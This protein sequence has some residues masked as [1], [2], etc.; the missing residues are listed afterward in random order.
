VLWTLWS[1]CVVQVE[2]TG[3]HVGEYFVV[4]VVEMLLF[5]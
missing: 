2:V 4:E 1:I 5:V 3:F